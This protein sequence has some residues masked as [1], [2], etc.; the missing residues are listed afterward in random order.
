MTLTEFRT[1]IRLFVR[2]AKTQAISNAVLDVLINR[3]VDDVNTHALAYKG[4]K[5]FAVTAEQSIYELH[6]AVDD[7]FLMD[8]AGVWW[9]E[10]SASSPKWKKMTP[11]SRVILD[12]KFPQ[13]KDDDSDDPYRYIVEGNEL[14]FHPTPDTDL[15]DGFWAFYIKKAKAMTQ[16][17]HYPFTGSTVE[18]GNFAILD[19][20]IV[21]Y[22]RW[23]LA[24]P[25]GDKER[26]I[27]TQK[28]YQTNLQS[29]IRLFRQRPDMAASSGNR[30]KPP[31]I[32]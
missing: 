13:W 32:C 9:N 12:T 1:I 14:I 17:G 30:M 27:L 8:E 31:I 4:N 19:D 20:A 11:L 6:T 3:G 15:S 5:K 23:K 25:L 7:Y 2:G 28:E 21:D 26:G 18:I 10:G 24:I 22:V 16:G 29:R